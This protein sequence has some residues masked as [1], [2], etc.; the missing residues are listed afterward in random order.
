MV[1]P[2]VVLLRPN[3]QNEADAA[4]CRSL[5]WQPIPF[6]TH[7]LV[8]DA[9]A[10]NRLPEKG[11][12]AD[13]VFW[14]SPGA[15]DIA[16]GALLPYSGS[17]K[18]IHIAVGEA[19][20]RRLREL[21]F[22][23]VICPQDGHDSEAV[24]RLPLWREK[25][26]KLLIVRGTFGRDVLAETVRGLGWQVCVAEVYSR[27]TVRLDWHALEVYQNTGCLKAVYVTAVAQVHEWFCQAPPAFT[28][29]LKRLL[30]FTHHPRIAEA[31]AAHQVSR[32]FVGSLREGLSST[33]NKETI[34][35]E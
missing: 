33:A 26:G 6:G 7:K 2:A 34:N 27:E 30:Y 24:L 22:A 31:L 20:A 1:Q 32:I 28:P 17:L 18:P 13:A 11:N 16:A 19:T 5:G 4:L 12:D 25:T 9:A 35:H 3:T 10:L 15:A 23:Q 14:V 8:A 21:G 29:V